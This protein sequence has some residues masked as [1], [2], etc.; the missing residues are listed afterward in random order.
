MLETQQVAPIHGSALRRPGTYEPQ[1]ARFLPTDTGPTESPIKPLPDQG[2]RESA[3]RNS[4]M[5]QN[6][7]A[8][9]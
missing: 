5:N 1:S 8:Y 7:G 4:R 9:G 2:L 6:E 3:S